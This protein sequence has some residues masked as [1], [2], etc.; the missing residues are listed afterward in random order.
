MEINEKGKNNENNLKCNDFDKN[1]EN[2]ILIEIWSQIWCMLKLNKIEYIEQNM[3][4]RLNLVAVGFSN[5]KIIIINLNTSKIHQEFKTPNTVYS[6]AQFKDDSKYL[7]C[8]LSNGKLFIFILNGV[9]YEEYQILEKPPEIKK[10]GINKVITLSDGTLA[11]ADHGSISIWKSNIEEGIKKFEFFKEIITNND[12]CQLLEVNPEIFVCAIYTS[13]LINLYKNDGY[14]Y[15][16]LGKI[17]NV[18]SHGNNS[19]GMAKINENIFCSG[20]KYGH[21]YIISVNPI[22][23]IQKIIISEGLNYIRFLY[24]SNDGF[25]FTALIDKIIQYKIIKDNADNFIQ[26]EKYNIIED[27]QD[28]TAII[29]TDDGKIFYNQ[30][31]KNNMTKLFLLEYIKK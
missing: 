21:I 7:I 18:E 20:G 19:N 14:E 9:K 15:Q 31:Y 13:K 2:Y 11:T 26:L 10:G 28:N 30:K 27:G 1:K 12:T 24:N 4:I 3:N 22:Q 8:S 16:L 6:L 17:I 25:I 5:G 23:I 29:T